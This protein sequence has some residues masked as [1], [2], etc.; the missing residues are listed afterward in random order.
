MC[1]VEKSTSETWITIQ[2]ST[3]NND[4]NRAETE[5]AE[6]LKRGARDLSLEQLSFVEVQ[7]VMLDRKERFFSREDNKIPRI[8][9]KSVLIAKYDKLCIIYFLWILLY[10][11]TYAVF[12]V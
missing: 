7:Q 3:W 11:K 4:A 6:G 1:Y 9:K 12:V 5:K 10:I 8:P 2:D